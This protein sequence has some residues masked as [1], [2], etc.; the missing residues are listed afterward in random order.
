VEQLPDFDGIGVL[1]AEHDVREPAD[2]PGAQFGNR[3]FTG[4]ATRSGS[5]GDA[6]SQRREV[7]AVGDDTRTGLGSFDDEAAPMLTFAVAP[8]EVANIF[9]RRPVA[10]VDHAFINE[11]FEF[12]G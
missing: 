6:F 5:R 1:D 2:G 11:G 9:A 7:H 3:N 10:V 4:F 12:L 8:D